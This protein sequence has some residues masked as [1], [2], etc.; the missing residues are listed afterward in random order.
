MYVYIYLSPQFIQ[1]RLNFWTDDMSYVLLDVDLKL[2]MYFHIS[3][4]INTHTDDLCY[5]VFKLFP[6][7]YHNWVYPSTV[8]SVSEFD[9]SKPRSWEKLEVQNLS[10]SSNDLFISKWTALAIKYKC[11]AIK[12]LFC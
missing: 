12:K 9:E 8:L 6:P 10:N 5:A 3:T 7:T 11:Y 2:S 4:G 1:I